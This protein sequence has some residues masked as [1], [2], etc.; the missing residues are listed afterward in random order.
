MLLVVEA[1]KPPSPPPADLTPRILEELPET[2]TISDESVAELSCRISNVDPE[3]I[4]WSKNERAARR[5]SRFKVGIFAYICNLNY[6][7]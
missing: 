3:D 4:S 5:G 2:L 7:S 1:V 6:R